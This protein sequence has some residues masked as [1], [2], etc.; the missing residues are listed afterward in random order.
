MKVSS[1]QVYGEGE[2]TVFDVFIESRAI[3]KTV[4]DG[5]IVD[6]G[7]KVENYRLDSWVAEKDVESKTKAIYRFSFTPDDQDRVDT[8]F[9]A[10]EAAEDMIIAAETVLTKRANLI[11]VLDNWK[12]ITVVEKTL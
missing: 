8:L 3:D 5:I 12:G 10:I 2:D 11:T 6:T 9:K 1:Y 4:L 7:L